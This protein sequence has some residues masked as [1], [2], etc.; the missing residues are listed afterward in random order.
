MSEQSYDV[1]VVGAGPGGLVLTRQLAAK[2]AN[3]ITLERHRDVGGV[4]DIDAPGSPMYDS[5]H[6]ISSKTLS[7]FSDYP[8]PDDFPDYPDHRKILG[9]IRNFAEHHGLRQHIRFNSE[10]V[11]ARRDDDGRWSL[12]L[13]DGSVIKAR[14]LIC[15]NGVTWEPNLIN[16][17][18]EFLGEI[19]H[20]VNYRSAREFE[21]KRVLIVGCGNSGVDIACDAAFAADN[22]FLST[23]R[24]Y[25]F[26][27]K[28]IMGVP[29]DVF[30]DRG[31]KLPFR[32]RQIVFGI[33]LR[34]IHGKPEDYGMPTPD[35]RILESHPLMNTQILHYIKHGDCTIKP[36]IKRFE[37][38]DVVFEDG[39]REAIDLVITATG[40]KHASPYLPDDAWDDKDGR[41]DLYMRLFSKKYDNL[42]VLGFVEFPSAAYQNFEIMA[43]LIVAD[44]LASPDSW[45]SKKLNLM[46]QGEE[47]DLKGGH[48]YVNSARHANYV[49]VDRYKRELA[50]IKQEIGVSTSAGSSGAAR[51]E[52]A[53]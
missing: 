44:A 33:L 25:Y 12:E 2:K 10:V 31:P 32:L 24:G 22:A 48:S 11:Q 1:A 28:H 50:R 36:G 16:W 7:G 35:H 17:P 38:H 43:E 46:K 3:F 27:P 49:D 19:R 9:F 14:Y 18:G 47:P 39:S 53:S 37:G 42:A 26:I 34:L 40:Y 30:A 45:L 41:P 21:G 20:S 5:A 15:A 23:R 8:M 4:W 6:F 13:S 29:A 52:A 51:V